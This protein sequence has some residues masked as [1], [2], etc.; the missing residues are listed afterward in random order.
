M[1]AEMFVSKYGIE[2]DVNNMNSGYFNCE[3]IG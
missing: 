2:V 3:K 1:L